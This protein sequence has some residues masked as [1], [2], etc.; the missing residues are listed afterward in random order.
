[1]ARWLWMNSGG[2]YGGEGGTVLCFSGNHWDGQSLGPFL[3]ELAA[4]ELK[5]QGLS[6]TVSKANQGPR[7]GVQRPAPGLSAGC[8]QQGGIGTLFFTLAHMWLS[9]RGAV[10]VEATSQSLVAPQPLSLSPDVTGL[11]IWLLGLIGLM[12]GGSCGPG[13]LTPCTPCH[14]VRTTHSHEQ[15]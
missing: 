12:F 9:T 5:L 7:N 11:D 14:P 10:C 8:P 3:V 4:L 6:P 15:H 1:M 2:F 13:S